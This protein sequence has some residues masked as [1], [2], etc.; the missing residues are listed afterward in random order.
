MPL[1]HLALCRPL[2]PSDA[3]ASPTCARQP[4]AGPI[5]FPHQRGKRTSLNEE[6]IMKTSPQ[7]ASQRSCRMV[8]SPILLSGNTIPIARAWLTQAAWRRGLPLLSLALTWLALP[9]SAPTVASNTS[10][11][12]QLFVATTNS[13]S[14]AV[15][16]S[17]TDQVTATIPV[18]TH[19]IRLA[20][21]PD[22]LKVYVSNTGS[23]SVSVIDT[24]NRI[25]TATIPTGHTG[26]QEITVTPDGGRVFVVHQNSGDCRGD[27]HSDRYPY[28]QSAD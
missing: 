23:G 21:T 6:V 17:A 26:P 19:P 25:V 4:A 3:V 9:L 22:G 15:I 11:S 5:P 7:N 1:L 27:R 18:G 12:P 16:D 24:V 20:M 28:H 13:H 2:S 10:Y 14:V 8:S